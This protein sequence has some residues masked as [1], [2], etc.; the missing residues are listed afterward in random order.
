MPKEIHFHA[1]TVRKF[2]SLADFHIFCSVLKENLGEDVLKEL[3]HKGIAERH[4]RTELEG[5]V[6][7]HS[8]WVVSEIDVAE[9]NTKKEKKK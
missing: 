1:I 3:N 8:R 2:K 4:D 7:S 9:P 5:R 6:E